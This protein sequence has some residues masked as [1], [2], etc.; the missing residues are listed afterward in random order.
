MSNQPTGDKQRTKFDRIQLFNNYWTAW[1]H[2]FNRLMLRYQISHSFLITLLYL[3]AATVGSSDD[4]IGNLA[5]TQIPARRKHV[6]KWL[7]KKHL[8]NPA[9]LGCIRQSWGAKEGSAYCYQEESSTFEDWDLL[10]KVLAHLEFF[11]GLDDKFSVKQ[12]GEMVASAFKSGEVRLPDGE[13]VEVDD[14]TKRK[15]EY[16]EDALEEGVRR[17]RS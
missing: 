4:C 9:F 10:F 7:G 11:G 17:K 8:S 3:W 5:L 16:I 12:F 1:P 15:I 13:R 2:E 6:E 14:V